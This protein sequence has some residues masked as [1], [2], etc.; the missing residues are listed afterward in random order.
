MPIGVFGP[1]GTTGWN[2]WGRFLGSVFPT[3]DRRIAA[4]REGK[5]ICQEIP[6]FSVFFF[7]S[8]R[9]VASDLSCIW[10]FLSHKKKTSVE[11]IVMKRCSGAS[12]GNC[13]F[14]R[15][16]IKKASCSNKDSRDEHCHPKGNYCTQRMP[17]STKIL[18][19]R[20]YS[21]V[22]HTQRG[23]GMINS[24]S[25]TITE[26]MASNLHFKPWNVARKKGWNSFSVLMKLGNLWCFFFCQNLREKHF[27]GNFMDQT[28]IFCW[29]NQQS[30]Q[31]SI[32]RA[33]EKST[34]F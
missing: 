2:V 15:T 8:F 20:H 11:G 25:I 30:H 32:A 24:M 17:A 33:Y 3:V 14:A 34:F 29:A 10:F 4:N 16:F 9:R 21:H 1:E 22:H 13:T 26:T 31:K 6:E 12:S 7:L 19:L 18:E 28:A 5:K 27:L 23:N